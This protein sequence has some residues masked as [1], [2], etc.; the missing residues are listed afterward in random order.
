[1]L[2]N[3]IKGDGKM[4]RGMPSGTIVFR[5]DRYAAVKLR[6]RIKAEL[7]S[8]PEIGSITLFKI[9]LS[10]GWIPDKANGEQL[11]EFGFITHFKTVK[12]DLNHNFSGFFLS[13]LQR[14]AVGSYKDYHKRGKPSSKYNGLREIMCATFLQE[15]TI[16]DILILNGDIE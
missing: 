13:F 1:M 2:V 11:D 16:R 10:R 3:Y 12:K 4:P 6:Q 14:A 9:F 5:I 15:T 8:S 7:T